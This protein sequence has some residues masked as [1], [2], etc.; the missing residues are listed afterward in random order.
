[1][2]QIVIMPVCID[3]FLY[4]SI[5]EPKTFTKVA[6]LIEDILKHPYEGIGKPEALKHE[7]SGCWSR[8]I[9]EKDRLIY[10][11]SDTEINIIAC[12]YHYLDK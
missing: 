5:Y 10:T 11:V 2:R 1:M 4:M 7:F 8:K 3:D 12:K 9:N 6:K